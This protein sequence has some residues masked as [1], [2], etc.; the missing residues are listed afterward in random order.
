MREGT[1][2]VKKAVFRDVA[3]YRCGVNRHLHGTTSQ[4]TTF[5]IV[6]AVKT[7]DAS[8]SDRLNEQHNQKCK[9]VVLN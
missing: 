8:L 7:S 1:F 6:T 4:K 9:L 5:F 2:P 3:P